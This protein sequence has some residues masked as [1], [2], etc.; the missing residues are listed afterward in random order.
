MLADG[1]VSHRLLDALCEHLFE[2]PG[3]YLDEMAAFLWDEFQTQVTK[4]SISRA[5]AF[6]GWSK[7]ITQQRAR[8]CKCRL[9]GCL[10]S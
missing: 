4:P 6:R 9:T 8:E 2:K 1:G 7:K 3:L 10:L 5:L